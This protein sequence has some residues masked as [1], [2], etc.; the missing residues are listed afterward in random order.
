MYKPYACGL[1][2]HATIDGCVQLRNAHG[3]KAKDIARIDVRAGHLVLVLTGQENPTTGLEGKFSIFHTA[4]VAIVDGK[5][6][7][8]RVLHPPGCGPISVS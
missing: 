5:A 2:L 8:R 4:A 1:W 3:L 6:D 7:R